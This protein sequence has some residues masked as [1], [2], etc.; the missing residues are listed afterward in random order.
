RQQKKK[1]QV[2]LTKNEKW[3]NDHKKFINLPCM[4]KSLP[5]VVLYSPDGS[6]VQLRATWCPPLEDDDERYSYDI[7]IRTE[8]RSGTTEIINT[9]I[10]KPSY[11]CDDPKIAEASLISFEIRCIVKLSAKVK[12][13]KETISSDEEHILKGDW[14]EVTVLNFEDETKQHTEPDTAANPDPPTEVTVELTNSEGT[15]TITGSISLSDVPQHSN[16]VIQLLNGDSVLS[17][18]PTTLSV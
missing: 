9:T 10:T 13:G 14:S 6:P 11:E 4:L 3:L 5:V 2:L 12:Y 8:G 18:Q 17:S 1:L 15:Y 7:R 16:I